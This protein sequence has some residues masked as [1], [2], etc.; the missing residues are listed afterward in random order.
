MISWTRLVG[1]ALWICGLAVCLATLSMAH[2][3]A[4]TGEDRLRDRLRGP[5]SR[6][7]I[8]VG[9]I[10]LCAGLLLTSDVWWEKG[11]WGLGAALLIY[12]AARL[13]RRRGADGGEGV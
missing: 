12:W 10:L 5:S 1:S 11:I 8:A 4:R 3:R 9:L 7:A 6:L 13:W 2:Y